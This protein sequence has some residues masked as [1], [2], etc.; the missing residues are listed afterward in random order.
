M[1][2]VKQV[3]K[4]LLGILCIGFWGGLQAQTAGNY[5]FT[6]VENDPLQVQMY[7]LPNGLQ[8]FLSV[9]KA[10]PRIQAYIPVKVGS[11]H[12]PL[13]TTGLAHYFEH[14]MFKGTSHF[15][16]MDFE[17][18]NV[19]LQAISDQFEVYRNLTD[20]AERAAAYHVIDSLS[21]EASKL[22]IPNEYDKLM[23]SIG[24]TGTNAGTSYDFTIYIENVPSN[25]LEN[26]AKVQAE[27]LENMVLRLFHTEIETVYEEKNMSLTN[28]GR[29]VGE[30]M[31]ETLFPHHPYGIHNVLGLGEHLKNPSLK[32]IQAFY[33][34]YYVPNNMA[35][36]LSGDFDP[37]EAMAIIEKYFGGLKAKD[38]PEFT[39]EKEAPL[40][41]PIEKE[42]V[43]LEAER[44][45]VGFPM[46]GSPTKEAM[47][48]DLVANML[49]NGQAGL[50]DLDLNQAQKVMFAYAYPSTLVDC[51]I[52]TL[53]GMPKAGQTLEEV[54]DLM[55]EGLNRIKDGDF[56]DWML[57]AT[58]DNKKYEMYKE[59]ETNEGRGMKIAYAYMEGTPWSE[60]VNYIDELS[61]V[62]KEDV[63]KFAAELLARHYVVVYKR[64]GE[65]TD[66]HKVEKP[67]IT[68][69]VVNR[70]VES[71]FLT[72]LK[73]AAAQVE[74][75]EPQFIDYAKDIETTKIGK[76]VDLYYMHNTE[77]PTFELT[78]LFEMGDY[79]DLLYGLAA[80]YLEYLGTSKLSAPEV[81]EE[82]YKIACSYSVNTTN[83]RIYVRLSGL[84]ENMEKAV[85]LFENLIKDCQPDEMALQ[86]MKGDILKL[87]HDNK[88][89]Q[90]ENVSALV[91]YAT[92]GPNSPV[93][94]ILSEE[95]LLA[96]TS[97]DLIKKL[98]TMFHTEHAILYYGPET[99]ESVAQIMTKLHKL[100]KK[101]LPVPAAVRFEPLATT[102]NRVV[103]APYDAKQAYCYMVS[104]GE[105]YERDMMPV[106]NMYN[107]YFGGGMNAI[108]FQ[109]LREKRSLAYQS[110]SFYR[111]PNQPD[112]YFVNMGLIITQND[113]VVD[114]F[115]AFDE[116]YENMPQ[117]EKGLELAKISLISDLRTSRDQKTDK[118]FR[119]LS[120]KKFGYTEDSR[121]VMYEAIP[122]ITMEDIVKFQQ[123][124]I[125]G[126]PQTYIIL[127]KESDFDF[128]KLEREFGK[129]EKVTT[130]EIFGY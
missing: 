65:P 77:N 89:N 44:V 112:N 122:G 51:G 33:E 79:N 76:K 24:S 101:M 41:A 92:Y 113:K 3:W 45:S 69:I 85:T 7:T 14:M 121:K 72:D 107:N 16:T 105:K 57:A 12:D 22:A 39:F 96:V 106:I 93:R 23:T 108:V 13:E 25:Q 111:R 1:S 62:T 80:S 30:I 64:Q 86:S 38:V 42:F 125:K 91:S 74:P 35:I 127:G 11:K 110:A 31:K 67:A 103:F 8:V 129:V 71:R 2:K 66:I 61:K 55:L 78:Y 50:Y 53:G 82:F 10:E 87:R 81:R 59:L 97:A 48:G 17:K 98:Q 75:I 54:K 119:Y 47:L 56:P 95:Q 68:P 15:G 9:N 88:S 114:A 115:K 36:V 70:D 40:Q 123:E 29:R 90:G 60:A 37:Q 116:L 99:M 128:E 4:L 83:E 20:S 21:Y 130:E 27:R 58:I 19:L 46:G 102:E 5:Q 73:A 6:T 32:N 49:Y 43:G 100:P 118:I 18:E 34:T 120:D 63:M 52:F 126:Q 104:R 28:D 109:E 26:W 94:H 124:K 117:S 84:A